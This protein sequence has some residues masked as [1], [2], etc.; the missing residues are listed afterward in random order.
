MNPKNLKQK[1]NGHG[2]WNRSQT[3]WVWLD[4]LYAILWYVF[5]SKKKEVWS[6]TN[7]QGHRSPWELAEDEDD[8]VEESR[9]L[10][11]YPC[12]IP[13]SL[14]CTLISYSSSSLNVMCRII[15]CCCYCSV[16]VRICMQES[17]LRESRE[18]RKWLESES[19]NEFVNWMVDSRLWLLMIK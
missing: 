13:N 14:I 12:K 18:L 16:C 3:I 10:K 9:I 15:L 1:L 8:E 5:W 6:A 7:L 2:C 4:C 19:F 17:L 11:K